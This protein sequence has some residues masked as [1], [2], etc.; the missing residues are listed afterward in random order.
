[1]P[2]LV[3]IH[4]Y[5]VMVRFKVQL[6]HP[7]GVKLVYG[8]LHFFFRHEAEKFGKFIFFFLELSEKKSFY[9]L[10]LNGPIIVFI[11]MLEDSLRHY[12]DKLLVLA[13]LKIIDIALDLLVRVL[14]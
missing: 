10:R 4:F 14:S 8:L 2:I 11:Q 3:C 6:P 13:L 7:I 5:H 1:M 9:L 12:F